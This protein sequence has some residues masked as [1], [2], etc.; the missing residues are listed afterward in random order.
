[1]ARPTDD[2]EWAT[3]GGASVTEPSA[4]KKTQGWIFAEKPPSSWLNWLLR[5][6]WRYTDYLMQVLPS[7][8][9]TSVMAHTLRVDGGAATDDLVGVATDGGVTFIAVVNVAGAPNISKSVNGGRTWALTAPTMGEIAAPQGIMHDGTRWVAWGTTASDESMAYSTDAG[10]TWTGKAIVPATALSIS[11]IAFGNSLYVAVGNMGANCYTCATIGGTWVQRTWGSAFTGLM[12]G[13]CWCPS[14]SLWV[15]VGGVGTTSEIQ[16]S[17]D[18]ITWTRRTSAT[19]T[20]LRSVKEVIGADNTA[21][22]LAV[23]D[24]GEIETSTNGTAWSAI[25]FD[26][27]GGYDLLGIIPATYGALVVGTVGYLAVA[28]SASDFWPLPPVLILNAEHLYGGA[29]HED[30][31]FVF[32]GL[33]SSLYQT[34]P[35]M[36]K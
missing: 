4:L 25:V 12:S 27:A 19:S 17:P 24:D 22:I 7:A 16:T 23:G 15:A 18:G 33:N 26:T 21:F 31:G 35:V 13:V 2:I 34:P 32:C 8:L 3:D 10:V 20:I 11:E 28:W 29:F 30:Y 6:V 9:V 14:I 36:L 5:A 1:M